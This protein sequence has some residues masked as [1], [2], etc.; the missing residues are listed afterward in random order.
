MNM[1]FYD[2][3]DFVT[4]LSWKHPEFTPID[5]NRAEE[6]LD[7]DHYGL[8]KVKERIIQQIAVMALNRKQYGSIL[9]LSVRLAPVRQVSDRVLPVR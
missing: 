7:E 9:L 8:K 1:A 2:Y 3:L 5:L 4:S 6:I